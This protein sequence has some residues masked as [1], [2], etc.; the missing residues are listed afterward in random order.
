MIKENMVGFADEKIKRA[1][2][3]LNQGKGAEQQ[4]CEF[5]NRAFDDLKFNPFCGIKIPKTLWPKEYV[6]KYSIDNLW[7]YDLPD[8]WRLVYTIRANQV[9]I[10]TVVLEWF[11]HK[12]YERRFNY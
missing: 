8:G 7:K 10:L 6:R 9:T 3:D 1:F 12:E 4:L 2:L 11:D 5:L